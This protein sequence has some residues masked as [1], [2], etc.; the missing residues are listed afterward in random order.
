MAV[1][2]GCTSTGWVG[3]CF[4]WLFVQKLASGSDF[5]ASQKTGQWLKVSSDRLGEAGKTKVYPLQVF[6]CG[7]PGYKPVL[8][9]WFKICVLVL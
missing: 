1:F 9:G 7:F 8:P 5:K 2:L 6:L 3:L 4:L